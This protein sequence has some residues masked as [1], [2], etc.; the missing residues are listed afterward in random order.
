[1]I[2]RS[3][4]RQ[5]GKNGCAQSRFLRLRKR[6]VPKLTPELLVDSVKGLPSVYRAFP[7][8]NFK[9]KVTVKQHTPPFP[10]PNTIKSHDSG[11]ICTAD[12]VRHV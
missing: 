3:E 6:V 5:G 7:K 2:S 11:A 10:E 9:G 8:V 12:Y 4:S 1:M